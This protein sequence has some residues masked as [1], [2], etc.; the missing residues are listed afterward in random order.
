MHATYD[1]KA[2]KK[3]TNVSI[4]SELLRKAKALKINLSASLEQALADQVR[5]AEKAQWQ[6]DNAV[7]IETYNEFVAQHGSFADSLRKF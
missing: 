7:A 1:S 2:P 3:A 5:A 6:Q 4:N